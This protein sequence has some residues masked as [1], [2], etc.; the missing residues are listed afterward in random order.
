MTLTKVIKCLWAC[1]YSSI[2]WRSYHP[3]NYTYTALRRFKC[4]E[5]ETLERLKERGTPKRVVRAPRIYINK[6][7]IFARWQNSIKA[8][9][10]QK[11]YCF[12]KTSFLL[13]KEKEKRRSKMKTKQGKREDTTRRHRLRFKCQICLLSDTK[14]EL[15]TELLWSSCSLPIEWRRQ[16]SFL[17]IIGSMKWVHVC[18]W[19]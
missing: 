3:L 19:A 4:A 13:N 1:V 14:S 16:C 9:L 10:E 17:R 2:K 7:S 12:W 15:L 11:R 5:W 18:E 6:N 8:Y